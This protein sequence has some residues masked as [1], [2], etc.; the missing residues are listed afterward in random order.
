MYCTKCGKEINNESLF[1]PYC[2][3][4]VQKKEDIKEQNLNRPEG[5]DYGILVIS[6][7]SVILSIIP[8]SK[9]III[10]GICFSFI[11]LVLS[12]YRN[13]KYKNKLSFLSIIVAS[14]GFVSNISWLLF[15]LF[16]L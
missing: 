6:A 8:L 9:V 14:V 16:M 3:S 2:G 10:V 4:E 5:F 12:L 1:C 13:K 11:G 15:I 7:L